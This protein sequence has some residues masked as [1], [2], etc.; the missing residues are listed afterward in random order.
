MRRIAPSDYRHMPWKNGLGTTIEIAIEPPGA[1]LD[2]FVYRVSMATLAVDGPF[3]SFP[4]VD[5]WI[6][7]LD[8][9]PVVLGE[10]RLVPLAPHA[11]PG[12]LAPHGRLE[13]PVA[14]D[15]NLMLRRGRA[16]GKLEVRTLG[17]GE[18]VT[19]DGRA[20]RIV[21]V[22][23]GTVEAEGVA[24]SEGETLWSDGPVQMGTA[25]GATTIVATIV[26]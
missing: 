18:R 8:G 9:G 1:T 16:T 3:S 2:D 24:A 7:L 20:T 26:R 17:A 14:R 19:L 23:A 25:S 13:G 12:E 4:A 15:F 10:H 21:F 5:R 11:F 6:V 22:A